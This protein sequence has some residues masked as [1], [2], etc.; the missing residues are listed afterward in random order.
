MKTAIGIGGAASG[1]R[2]DRDDTVDFVVEAIREGAESAAGKPAP[3][4]AAGFPVL[5]TNDA[6]AGRE[7]IARLLEVYG[8]LPSY[9]AMLDREGVQGPADLALAGD[10]K[11]I[12]DGIKR[13]RRPA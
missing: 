9:R 10:E 12:R 2:R 3:Q 5:L 11:T 6:D 8:M 1:R 4:V 13:T 7:E